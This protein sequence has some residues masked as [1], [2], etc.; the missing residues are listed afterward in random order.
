MKRILLF[1]IALAIFFPTVTVATIGVGVGTGKIHVQ[2]KLKPGT[3]YELPPLTVINTGDQPSEYEVSITYHEKQPQLPPPQDWFI[4]SPQK[5]HLKPGQVQTVNIKLNLPVRGEPGE[6][7]A[8]LEAHPLKK[9]QSGKT[10]IGV[11]AAAKLYFTVIPANIFEAIYYKVLSFWNVY[12]PWPQRVVTVIFVVGALL[13]FKKFFKI[14]INIK[15]PRKS[16]EEAE[17]KNKPEQSKKTN[18]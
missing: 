11:A 7:F 8:Y 13:V 1:F 10:S 3:I 9:S 17:G 15:K 18:E 5:F 12:A 4:F 16:Q 6:Y 2:D 14:Q